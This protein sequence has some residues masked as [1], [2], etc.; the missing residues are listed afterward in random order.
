MRIKITHPDDLA[1]R[2]AL[3][4][5]LLFSLLTI[6]VWSCFTIDGSTM[7]DIL[8]DRDA[9]LCLLALF[10]CIGYF[11]FHSLYLLWVKRAER[12]KNGPDVKALEFTAQGVSIY[13]PPLAPLF[14]PYGETSFSLEV[15]AIKKRNKHTYWYTVS[16][17]YM[18]FRQKDAEICIPCGIYRKRKQLRPL[19][20]ARHRFAS[21]ALTVE[22]FSKQELKTIRHQQENTELLREIETLDDEMRQELNMDGELQEISQMLKEQQE[23]EAVSAIRRELED[24]MQYGIWPM[25]SDDMRSAFILYGLMILA[26]SIYM[27]SLFYTDMDKELFELLWWIPIYFLV[28]SA[29]LVYIGVKDWQVVRKL[30]RLKSRDLENRQRA[31]APDTAQK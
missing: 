26:G 7:D 5:V 28:L 18:T 12:R 16:A 29:V 2:N 17:V 21:F 13:R 25:L 14:F 10:A 31:A 4:I 6:I 20:D 15:I 11:L 24:Y 3:I 1:A 30:K 8:A 22:S 19:L 9:F 23:P 27:V